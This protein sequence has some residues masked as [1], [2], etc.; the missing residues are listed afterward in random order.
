MKNG[1]II[2]EE[3]RVFL[4]TRFGIDI[5]TDCWRNGAK[6]YLDCTCDKP[7]YTFKVEDKQIKLT[8]DNS[9]HFIDYKQKKVSD[10]L[11]EF[12]SRLKELEDLSVNFLIN[13]LTNHNDYEKVIVAHSTG[14]DSIVSL[15]MF[16]MALNKIKEE[17]PKLFNKINAL[18]ITNFANTTNDTGY[19][20]RFAK[21]LDRVNI[22]NPEKGL[23]PWLREDKK[24]RHP[25]VMMRTCCEKYKE[26]QLIKHF[27]T[28]KK[29]LM[30]TGVRKYESLKR[31]NYEYIMNHNERL[32]IHNNKDSLPELWDN[33]API[34]EWKDYEIWLYIMYK[35]LKFNYMY[36]LG[37]HRIGCLN[38]PYQQDYIDVLTGYYFAKSKKRWDDMLRESYNVNNVGKQ[39]K[40]TEEEY[41]DFGKWKTGTGFEHYITSLKMTPERVNELAKRKGCSED[42]ARKFWDR[43][44]SCCGKRLNPSEVSMSLKFVGRD[45]KKMCKSCLCKHLDITK[46]QYKE[47]QVELYNGDCTLF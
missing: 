45:A 2:F 11:V 21:S 3:E 30:I 32:R 44:C 28:T 39:L 42:I 23:I 7:I 14:K 20:Y 19:T 15:H 36:R 31:S 33:I 18:W 26:G 13:Y 17:N 6:I 34:V 16:T 10:L 8:K 4:E 9:K 37:F 27:D 29:I 43:E 38:C 47:K 25:T 40:W 35:N 1:K 24:Y 46:A 12:S 41:V 22:M 5:P